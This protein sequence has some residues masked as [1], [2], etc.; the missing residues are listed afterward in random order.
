MYLDITTEGAC[1]CAILFPANNASAYVSQEPGLIAEVEDH[2][3]SVE[4]W[5]KPT[6]VNGFAPLWSWYEPNT[7]TAGEDFWSVDLFIAG[8]NI[9]PR[10]TCG[11]DTTPARVDARGTV[12]VALNEW[13]HIVVNKIGTDR[14]NWEFFVNGV[15]S[16]GLLVS[17]APNYFYTNPGLT[18]T[19]HQF[20]FGKFANGIESKFYS[21]YMAQARL[22]NR[23][24]GMAEVKYNYISG[25]YKPFSLENLLTWTPFNACTGAFSAAIDTNLQTAFN[26][27]FIGNPWVSEC[28]TV[29]CPPGGGCE[30]EN[31][32]DTLSFHAC[33]QLTFPDLNNIRVPCEKTILSYYPAVYAEQN[34]ALCYGCDGNTQSSESAITPDYTSRTNH[35]WGFSVRDTTANSIFQMATYDCSTDSISQNTGIIDLTGVIADD[36]NLIIS[37]SFTTGNYNVFFEDGVLYV[38]NGYC[39]CNEAMVFLTRRLPTPDTSGITEDPFYGINLGQYPLPFDCSDSGCVSYTIINYYD[40]CVNREKDPVC[41]EKSYYE[42]ALSC[43]PPEGDPCVTDGARLC[44][45]SSLA[46]SPSFFSQPIRF[47]E[48]DTILIRYRNENTTWITQRIRAIVNKAGYNKRQ[49]ISVSSKGI[50]RKLL[51]VID[52]TFVITTDYYTKRWH[53]KM[54][55]ALESDY[56]E[57][58][59]M[60][61]WIGIV[62][63]ETYKINWQEIPLPKFGMGEVTVKKSKY[64][65]L[66]TFC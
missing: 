51:S 41:V 43:D 18:H 9:Y 23:A 54:L 30:D 65:Y 16:T 10:L 59:F 12:P 56:I 55:L 48:C 19:A 34:V 20:Q 17:A 36:L 21:G 47:N 49:E 4:I 45:R 11:Y 1:C 38:E 22:Y 14:K 29:E 44:F 63:D 15:K 58:L 35:Y 62:A 2:N 27:N 42:I 6:S 39:Q 32:E 40:A 13:H 24:L 66:N 61:E 37:E 25:F 52:E 3:F 26:E 7:Y 8:G 50:T 64:K 5:V 53:D 60:G 31:P 57:V 33:D 28:P 46:E